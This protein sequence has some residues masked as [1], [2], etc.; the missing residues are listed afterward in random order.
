MSPDTGELDLRAATLP[1]G[2]TGDRLLELHYVTRALRDLYT[3]EGA[4]TAE[5]IAVAAWSRRLVWED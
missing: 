3:R 2:A 4:E 5:T 1:A